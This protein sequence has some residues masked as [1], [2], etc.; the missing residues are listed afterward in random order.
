MKVLVG[1]LTI[2]VKKWGWD[3]L[4]ILTVI[5]ERDSQQWGYRHVRHLLDNF[6]HKVQMGP[7]LS[8]VGGDEPQ[9]SRRISCASLYRC[10]SACLNM[11][12][13]CVLFNIWTSVASFILV[14]SSCTVVRSSLF[15]KPQRG[16]NIYSW[17]VPHLRKDSRMLN[18]ML[19]IWC[20]QW[21][22]TVVL[23]QVGLIYKLFASLMSN[24][25]AEIIQ[26]ESLR[27]PEVWL[28]EHSG[29]RR[30]ILIFGTLVVL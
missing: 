20:P 25:F 26:P 14:I 15:L 21:S 28:L 19:T 8:R 18:W 30:L 23:V 5:R 17:L 27:S 11:F 3:E 22:S 29:I 13:V 7:H 24:R 4:G 2:A 1:D 6:T 16:N 12:C 9:C 10:S